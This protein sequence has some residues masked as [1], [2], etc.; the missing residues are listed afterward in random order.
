[1]A[2]RIRDYYPEAELVCNDIAPTCVRMLRSLGLETHSFD[3]DDGSRTPYP[4]PDGSF[5]AV[6]SL[7]TIEH[8]FD[9]D[10]YMREIHRLLCDG[11][12]LYITAPNYAAPEFLVP[13]VFTRRSFHDPAR[14]FAD[15]LTTE[16][17]R[18][19]FYTHIRYFTYRTL[20][21]Y[22]GSFGFTPDSVY[23]A[24][25]AG[26]SRY[27]ALL[28]KA[29]LAAKTYR[30]L[31]WL[32]HHLLSPELGDR[33]AALLPQGRRGGGGQEPRKVVL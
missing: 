23:L 30:W 7:V 6:L 32:R 3:L 16:E 19:E 11:G 33:A 12:Y 26:S 5:D 9:I 8:L 29:P 21:D 14:V 27:R 10:H 22:V 24:L 31:T 20:L 2:R 13:L 18:Y 28:R 25:P 17:S 1:M 4:F 15:P